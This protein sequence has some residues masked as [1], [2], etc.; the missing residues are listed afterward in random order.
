MV[1]HK[2]VFVT[3]L[4]FLTESLTSHFPQQNSGETH[5]TQDGQTFVSRREILE[6]SFVKSELRRGMQSPKWT[7]FLDYDDEEYILRTLD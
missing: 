4:T 6:H 3:L 1:S 5:Q 7:S 2:F